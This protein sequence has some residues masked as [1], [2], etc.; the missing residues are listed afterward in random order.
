MSAVLLS[1][2][3]RVCKYAVK[4]PLNYLNTGDVDRES[5]KYKICF[6]GKYYG[7]DHL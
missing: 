2:E 1:R 3:Q 4:I 7:Y 5:K 6:C